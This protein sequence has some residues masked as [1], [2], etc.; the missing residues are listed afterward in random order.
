[1]QNSSF[2]FIC[3]WLKTFSVQRSIYIPTKTSD[4]TVKDNTANAHF[5]LEPREG[6]IGEVRKPQEG[7]TMDWS[8]NSHQKER[9][10]FEIINYFPT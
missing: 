1:M 7:S 8:C 2:A 10:C 9:C 6:E 3:E 4:T 5:C